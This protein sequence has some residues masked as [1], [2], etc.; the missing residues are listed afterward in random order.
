MLLFGNCMTFSF[1]LMPQH[2]LFAL[3]PTTF[4]LTNLLN[5]HTPYMLSLYM[6][7]PFCAIEHV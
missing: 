7:S 6:L 1:T 4:L 2:P 3:R 5:L